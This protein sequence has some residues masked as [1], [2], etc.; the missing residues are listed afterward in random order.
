MTATSA[1]DSTKTAS[2]TV[3]LHPVAVTAAPG[4]VSLGAGKSQTFT[5]SVTG[6]SNTSVTWS[7]APAVGTVVNGT[8]TAPATVTSAQ[9]VTITAASVANS[10]KTASATISLT[11]T[12]AAPAPTSVSPSTSTIAPGGTKQ[13]S[14]LNLPSG[15]TV[16]W[17]IS[18]ATG[19]ITSAGLYTAPSTV[20]TQSTVTV[21]A[22]N[23]STQVV[24]GTGTLTLT[25]SPATTTT[26]ITLPIEA[27]GPNGYTTPAVSF[28][29]PQGTNLSGQLQLWLQIHGLK[30]QSE[31]SVQ[32]NNSAWT[33]INSSSVTLLG[34]A[35][36]YGGIGGG[37]HTL[38]MTMNLPAGA[39]TTGTNTISFRFN[40][41]DGATS[42][43]R[44]LGFNIQSGGSNLLSSS[45]FVWDDPN[46]WRPPSTAASDITAGQV[47][48]HTAGLTVPGVGAIKAHCSD[49]HSEDGRDLKY[50]NYSNNSIVVRSVFHGL[51]AAQGNQ[52]ASYIR[53]LNVPNPGRPWNP[54][55]QPG[56]G[57]DSKP[58]T[59]W[60]AG[61]GL[62]AVLDS[63]AEIQPYIAPGGSFAGW[64]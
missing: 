38:Q 59:D 56:P 26:T 43:Y 3:T 27:M 18:P 5:A 15:T 48:W 7:L 49:C 17:S 4:S 21:T 45:L 37:F 16:A 50:F 52:I 39:V 22:K 20:A 35:N 61:A 40:G 42:G 51:T 12:A 24:L 62:D 9:S 44:V 25:A 29:I 10:S 6:S 54:P 31:A 19:S 58:V 32:V 1:A 63:D 47:L 57:L 55:Y 34:L 2:A 8:Y 36:A 30:Y 11:A 14:V 53:S 33:A 46:S 23:S 60:A 64:S 13:L 28:T 41:T